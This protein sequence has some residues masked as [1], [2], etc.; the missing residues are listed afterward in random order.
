MEEVLAVILIASALFPP[1]PVVSAKIASDLASHLAQ[2]HDVT[3]ISP[4]PSRPYGMQFQERIEQVDYKHIVLDSYTHPKS[5][6]LGRLWESFS[7]GFHLAKFIE[8]NHKNIEVVYANVWPLFAQYL[9]ARVCS[10]FGIPFV[11]HVQDVYP[12]SLTNKIPVFG[13][14]LKALLLPV[15]RYILSKSASIIS[16][17]KQ[18]QNSLISTRQIAD[19]NIHVVRNWQDDSLFRE[20]ARNDS[21]NENKQCDFVFLYLGSVSPAAG[22]ELLIH[23]FAHADLSNASLVIAGSG[24]DKAKCIK[25][26]AGYNMTNI[27]FIDILPDQVPWLQA[28][29]DVLLLPLKKGIAATALPS[30]MTAYMF[31]AKPIIASVDESSEVAQIICSNDCGWVV[32]PED[33]NELAHIMHEAYNASSATLSDLGK[34]AQEFAVTYLSRKS[35]LRKLVQILES[36]RR[37]I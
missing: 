20:V 31:S 11:I 8:K 1:E 4:K 6:V 27:E 29:A 14:F 24:S 35:N 33:I 34:K 30:K 9:L 19:E 23:A 12:E 25:I 15:D 3:V 37:V 36:H 28:K 16:I 21:V 18:M 5:N 2:R 10:K 32:P 7:L 17:S 13:R 22:V 26:A